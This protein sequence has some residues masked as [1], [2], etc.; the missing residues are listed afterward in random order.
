[1][2]IPDNLSEVSRRASTSESIPLLTTNTVLGELVRPFQVAETRLSNLPKPRQPQS[3][4][5]PSGILTD[6][7]TYTQHTHGTSPQRSE[8]ILGTPPK[9]TQESLLSC[10]QSRPSGRIP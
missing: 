9:A 8:D 1:M 10:A 3:T 2:W 5:A 6:N 4:A 7:L